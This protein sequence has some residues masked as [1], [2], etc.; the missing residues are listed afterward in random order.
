MIWFTMVFCPFSMGQG[1]LFLSPTLSDLHLY[2][3][4]AFLL[5]QLQ[6]LLCREEESRQG[7]VSFTRQQLLTS[8][9]CVTKK[10][11]SLVSTWAH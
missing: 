2:S 8:P 6:V 7:S 3:E 10:G 11:L 4:V 9:A 1:F 5:Q